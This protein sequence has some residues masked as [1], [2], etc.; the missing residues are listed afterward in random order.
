MQ[1]YIRKYKSGLKTATPREAKQTR[2]GQGD[3]GHSGYLAGKKA[4]LN[5]AVDGWSNYPTW[6][7]EG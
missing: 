2:G 6:A 3:A 7:I 5:H 4:T 1:A